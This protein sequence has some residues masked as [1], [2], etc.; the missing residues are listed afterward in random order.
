MQAGRPSYL[1]LGHSRNELF[2]EG[3]SWQIIFLT[4]QRTLGRRIGDS[5]CTLVI[6]K[7]KWLKGLSLGEKVLEEEAIRLFLISP[8]YMDD[9]EPIHGHRRKHL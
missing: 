8:S 1:H 6:R 9:L 7:I 4:I 5:T 2:F 3:V